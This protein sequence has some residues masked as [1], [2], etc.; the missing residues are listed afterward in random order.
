MRRLLV[1]LL[2]ALMGA[3][4]V[5]LGAAPAQAAKC[6]APTTKKA[7]KGADVVFAGKLTQGATKGASSYTFE[8]ETLYA[9]DLA[10]RSVTVRASGSCPLKGLEPDSDYVVFARQSSGALT[11][12]TTDGTVKASTKVIHQVEGVL[13]TG[14]DLT[15][16]ASDTTKPTFTRVADATPPTLSRVAAPGVA[17][18]LIGLLGLLLVRRRA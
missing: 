17:M 7:A 2:L 13:G 12:A 11:T 15:S 10:S 4:L 1:S 3:G 8:A 5:S 14:R 6:S 9:G 18:V 16:G